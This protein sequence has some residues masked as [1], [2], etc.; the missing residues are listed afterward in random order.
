MK[1]ITGKANCG[2]KSNYPQKLKID[3]KIKTGEDGCWCSK[4]VK[5]REFQEYFTT[6]STE[7]KKKIPLKF[8]FT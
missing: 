3:N 6:K 5:N 2:N 8:I 7:S 4:R 1:E